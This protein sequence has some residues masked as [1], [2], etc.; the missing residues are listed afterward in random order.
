MFRGAFGHQHGDPR[1]LRE[2]IQAQLRERIQEAV[3]MAGLELMVELRRRHGQPVPDTDSA[4][5]RAEFEQTARALLR[6]LRTAFDA[7]L[8][9][10]Q[11]EGLGRAE[12]SAGEP[13]PLLAGQAFLA[14]HLPDYWQRFETYRAAYARGQLDA[15]P[16]RGGWLSRLLR[17]DQAARRPDTRG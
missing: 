15:P 10:E 2:R 3:E 7:E 9:A 17:N 16:T 1:G 14:S 11:R 12:S 6:H 4:A 8:A 13:E 5:D